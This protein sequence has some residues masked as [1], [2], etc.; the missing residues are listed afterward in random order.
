MS[1]VALRAAALL[2]AFA[3]A[4]CSRPVS[5]ETTAVSSASPATRAACR[6]RA[7]E[8]YARQ[9]RA[10][11]YRADNFATNARNTPFAAGS[12]LGEPTRALSSR[13]AREQLE[14]DCLRGAAGNIGST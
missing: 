10:D 4:A 2:A 5:F 11:I 12:V 14:D 13:Y 6:A 1:L 9:N 3:A 7:D 8:V